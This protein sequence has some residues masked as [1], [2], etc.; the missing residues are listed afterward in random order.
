VERDTRRKSRSVG[1]RG[2][3]MKHELAADVRI[4]VL[5][6]PLRSGIAIEIVVG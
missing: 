3:E 1:I 5:S 2:S 4:H 6:N